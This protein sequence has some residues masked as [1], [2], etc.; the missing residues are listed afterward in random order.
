[1]NQA[2]SDLIAA[3]RAL[4]DAVAKSYGGQG[5]G[6]GQSMEAS[7]SNPS[8]PKPP[9]DSPYLTDEEE[10]DLET[11]LGIGQAPNPL[12]DKI[13]EKHFAELFAQRQE[14]ALPSA[15]AY[16]DQIAV[17]PSAMDEEIPPEIAAM[18]NLTKER[19]AQPERPFSKGPKGINPRGVLDDFSDFWAQQG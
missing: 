12:L 13:T 7:Q 1:M 16:K 2:L 15:A 18:D 5:V 11:R 8:H 9:A 19:M 3:H 17:V 10:S 6:S 4:C 14:Q